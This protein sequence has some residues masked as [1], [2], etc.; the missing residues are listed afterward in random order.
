MRLERYTVEGVRRYCAA[1]RRQMLLASVWLDMADAR[2]WTAFYCDPC[3]TAGYAEK[4][5]KARA[6]QLKKSDAWRLWEED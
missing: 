3:V 6:K 5:A 2:R 1:C 4:A